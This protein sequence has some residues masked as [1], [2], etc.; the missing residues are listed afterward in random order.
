MLISGSEHTPLQHIVSVGVYKR[1]KESVARD[2]YRATKI[3]YFFIS[4]LI[5][6]A[7]WFLFSELSSELG[8]YGFFA[9]GF[10]FLMTFLY[11]RKVTIDF[12]VQLTKTSG[13]ADLFWSE[14]EDFVH[15]VN[16]HLAK[17]LA[18]DRANSIRTNINID[19]KHIDSITYNQH[20]I[21]NTYNTYN[22]DIVNSY[23]E[24]VNKEDLRFLQGEFKDSL[25]ELA[26]TINDLGNEK[27]INELERFRREM[28]TEKPDPGKLSKCWES[29]KQCS[30]GLDIYDKVMSIGSV[31]ASGITTLMV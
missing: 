30:E 5:L 18:D 26:E 21:Q 24:G 9:S 3:F 11:K 4:T 22:Y 31:V 2:V 6:I 28:K 8:F 14:D 13:N 23:Y 20:S 1:E 29:V 19:N 15:A 17:V 7:S 10:A 25:T 12:A 16:E 27:L